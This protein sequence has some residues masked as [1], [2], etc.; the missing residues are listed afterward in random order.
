MKNR[1]HRRAAGIAKG[2]RRVAFL[3]LAA[4][5]A[6][7]LLPLFVA[8]AIP[9]LQAAEDHAAPHAAHRSDVTHFGIA[10]APAPAGPERPPARHHV[11]HGDCV[12][13]LGMQLSGPAAL[14]TLPPLPIPTQSRAIFAAAGRATG[15]I[16]D[17]PV[18]YASRAPPQLG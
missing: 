14:P 15:I 3:G 10:H 7:T 9:S 8:L 2:W 18:H 13:C 11:A 17:A 12:L 16:A 6:Q 5:Y 1:R 4:L